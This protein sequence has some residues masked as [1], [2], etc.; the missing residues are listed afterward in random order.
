MKAKTNGAAVVNR[1]AAVPETE[2]VSKIT[3]KAPDLRVIRLT[4]RGDAPLVL[5]RFGEKARREIR[6]KQA[7]GSKAAAERGKGREARKPAEEYAEARHISHEGWDGIM[8][9]AFRRA[10][11]DA[12]RVGG[13]TMVMA[14]MSLFIVPDGIDAKDSSPLVRI[15]KGE[16][17][18]HEAYT[19][20]QFNVTTLAHRPMWA[21]GWEAVVSIRFN[22]DYVDGQS[23][24]NLLARAGQQIGV[25][26][27]RPFS[28]NSTGC[29]WGT[30]TIVGSGDGQ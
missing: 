30:F 12:C 18:Q 16:P 23:V 13:I 19:R 28:K 6:D 14:K 15:T 2:G 26:E 29:G 20:P 27:G 22:A 5:C 7:R 11:V 1:I 21:P 25:G 3:I 17:H 8:A 10:M 9:S 24:A 4:I